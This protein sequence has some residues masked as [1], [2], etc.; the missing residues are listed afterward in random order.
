MASILKSLLLHPLFVAICLASGCG[1]GGSAAAPVV[2]PA[3]VS[4]TATADAINL[5]VNTPTSLNLLTNDIDT[6]GTLTGYRI[7]SNPSHGSLSISG[8]SITYTPDVAYSGVDSFTYAAV[9]NRGGVSNSVSVSLSIDAI[10]ET[11]LQITA[12]TVPTSNYQSLNNADLNA[13]LLTSS[14]R[15]FSLPANTVS[16]GLY[17]T[18]NDVENNSTGL[19]VTRLTNP[20]NVALAQLTRFFEYCSP[21]LCA[22]LLPRRADQLTPRG[23]WQ[24]SLGTRAASLDNIDFNDISLKLA[25]RT[26]PAPDLNAALP[27]TLKV[28]PYFSATSVS[29][30]RF[31]LVLAEFVAINQA[32]SIAIDLQ[33]TVMLTAPE[34]AEVNIDFLDPITAEMVTQGAADSINIFFVESFSGPGGAGRLGI[35]PGI[36]GTLGVKGPYNGLL[37]NAAA[38]QSG[39]DDYYA[40]TTAEFAFHEM[41]HLLGLLHT[42]ES[43]FGNDIID[44]SADCLQDLDDA[45]NNNQADIDECPD[46]LNPM[47]WTNALDT[48][49]Q[50]LSPGQRRVIYYSPIATP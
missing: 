16:F 28:T 18:G 39:P 9:D 17:L 43:N 50:P 35:S 45:N 29:A 42:T 10:I 47:F 12:L 22:G 34:Y 5:M 41:G 25:V 3:N 4:P 14:L 36:P 46:G 31:A 48:I 20:D 32:N 30:A 19:L 15:E 38:T 40:R 11:N 49:K 26:G 8:T 6:D 37:I 7:D 2:I 27:A 13:S 21:G 24:Y 1:G 23:D 44:D 33:P